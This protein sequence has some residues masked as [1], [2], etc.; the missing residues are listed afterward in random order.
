MDQLVACERSFSK[1]A[2]CFER[3]GCCDSFVDPLLACGMIFPS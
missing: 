1:L 2:V 3:L